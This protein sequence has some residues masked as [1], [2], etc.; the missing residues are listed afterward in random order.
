MKH[1]YFAA[2]TNDGGV[3]HYTLEN[4]KLGFVSKTL[5]NRPMYLDVTEEDMKVVLQ[6]PVQGIRE[7][8]IVTYKMEDY[9]LVRE[10]E[11]QLTKGREGCHICRFEGNEY[12]AN[13]SSGSLFS[14][15]EK[16]D[17]HEGHGPNP[18]R[19]EM[20][21]IHFVK[22]SPDQKYLLSVDLGLDAIYTYD[23][24][25]NVVSVAH[26]PAGEGPRHLAYSADGKTVFCVNELGSSITVFS[27]EDGVLTPGESVSILT[28]EVERNTSGAIRVYGDYV[29]ASN[30]GDET[31]AACKWDGEHLTLESVTPCGGVSPRDFDIFDDLMFVTNE[32]TNNVTIFKVNGAELTK[33]E[34]ELIM[35]NPLCVVAL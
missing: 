3:Y 32:R 12:V 26:T 2:C 30:R 31:I 21:H 7:S 16:L 4:G 17:V 14:S 9:E 22:P 5:M 27:Y 33:L 8:A 13:Y 29:Y 28:H 10:S 1:L 6:S 18:K 24:D 11:L 15:A 34:E 25:L 20:P 23:K 19:Q 35:P